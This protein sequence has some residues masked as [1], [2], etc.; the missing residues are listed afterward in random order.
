MTKRVAV[1]TEGKAE[2]NFVRR[3]LRHELKDADV[4]ARNM[5]GG[6]ISVASVLGYIRPF[7]HEKFDCVTTMVDFYKFANPGRSKS[8]EDIEGELAKN[9][10]QNKRGG[11]G[12]V[13]LPYVQKHEFES[14]LFADRDAVSEYLGLSAAQHKKLNAVKGKPE[15]INHDAPP[16][17]RI[18]GIHGEYNKAVDGIEIIRNIGLAKIARECPRFGKW[19]S[20]LR[21][22]AKQ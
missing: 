19:L 4:I 1:V 22:I 5:R 15:D 3:I 6:G 14:L 13:F 9:A 21:K 17:K 2:Y 16:S 11:G 18:I 10:A 12:P 8:A 20:R 7:L